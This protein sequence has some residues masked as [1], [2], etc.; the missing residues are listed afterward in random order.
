M[1]DRTYRWQ[2]LSH[3][4]DCRSSITHILPV[5]LPNRDF[6]YYNRELKVNKI[7]TFDPFNVLFS[8][9]IENGIWILF[10]EKKKFFLL[11]FI[12]FYFLCFRSANIYMELKGYIYI[13]YIPI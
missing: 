3:F 7:N 10:E 1:C 4:S 2:K 13:V 9:V 11:L 8:R 12:L 5:L 6:Y